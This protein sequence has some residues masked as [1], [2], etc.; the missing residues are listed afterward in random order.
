MSDV[1]KGRGCAWEIED[2]GLRI[3]PEPGKASKLSMELGERF[4]PYDALADVV[5]APD[6]RGR[7]VLRV[8]PRQGADPVTSAGA[9]STSR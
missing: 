1:L 9:G 7:V 5:L 4:V 8:V 3:T 6:A 2:G